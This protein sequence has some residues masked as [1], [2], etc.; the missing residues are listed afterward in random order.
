M[1]MRM[2]RIRPESREPF[3]S[4]AARLLIFAQPFLA[5]FFAI[6]CL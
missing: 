6:R 4:L 5:D 2:R 3:F 1:R